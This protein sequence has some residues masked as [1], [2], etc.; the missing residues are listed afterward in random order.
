MPVFT[1]AEMH[2][3]IARLGKSISNIQ[4]HSMPKSLRKVKTF[5]EDEYL[6]EI[7]AASDDHCF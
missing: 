6:R 7:T 2:E 1:R 3:H 5:L 4:H